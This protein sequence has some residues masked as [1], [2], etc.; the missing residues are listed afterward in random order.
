MPFMR[1]LDWMDL[2]RTSKRRRVE[3]VAEIPRDADAAPTDQT[4]EV[5]AAKETGVPDA[6][7]PPAPREP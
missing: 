2:Q 7:R 3:D 5:Q 6:R 4:P 1:I